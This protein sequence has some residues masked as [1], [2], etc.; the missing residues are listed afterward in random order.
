MANHLRRRTYAAAIAAA[1]VTVV[2]VAAAAA[3]ADAPRAET[4]TATTAVPITATT[5][6][7]TPEPRV[8]ALF[9]RS[10]A[11]CH[12]TG[13]GGAPRVANIDDWRPR[14]A[15]G[16]ATLLRHAVEGFNSMPPLGYCQ[17]CEEN[18][19]RALTRF[20]ATGR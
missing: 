3:M 8:L 1:A 15:R 16:E 20:L 14:L 18:D 17:A 19:M 13:E 4:A 12:V 6:T 9:Q 10:C 7:A 2:V 11:L 5:T